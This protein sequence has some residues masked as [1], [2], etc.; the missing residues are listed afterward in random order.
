LSESYGGEKQMPRGKVAAKDINPDYVRMYYEHQNDRI[1]KYEDQSLNISNIVL[2]ISALIITFGLNSR[3]SFGSIL[4][5]FLPVVLI[6]ANFTAILYIRDSARWIKSH[7]TRAD[8]IL[9]IYIPELSTLDSE[10][11]APHNQYTFGRRRIQIF[12]HMLFVGLAIILV[13]LFT[14]QA[15]GVSIG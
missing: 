2:T 5:L 8:R 13:F 15:L 1:M 4:I 12:I 14:L 10:T 9:E 11:M 6:F 3:Q 7:R